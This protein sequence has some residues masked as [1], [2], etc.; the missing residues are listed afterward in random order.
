MSIQY[1]FSEL[2]RKDSY[3]KISFF[4]SAP[5]H[6]FTLHCSF[7]YHLRGFQSSILH[8]IAKTLMDAKPGPSYT[9][10]SIACDSH[11]N[12]R[13]QLHKSR[14][15]PPHLCDPVQL[16]SIDEIL[17]LAG[18]RQLV[19]TKP[20]LH[21]EEWPTWGN[22]TPFA[23]SSSLWALGMQTSRELTA[24]DQIPVPASSVEYSLWNEPGGLPSFGVPLH[25]LFKDGSV[26]YGKGGRA[27]MITSA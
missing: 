16:S 21:S 24:L 12:K 6:S 19:Q 1:P 27:W 4:F 23:F 2:G 26:S 17:L 9:T 14:A 5:F 18:K 13:L 15:F 3:N 8:I 22:S 25:S 20:S 11:K 10:T 7:C